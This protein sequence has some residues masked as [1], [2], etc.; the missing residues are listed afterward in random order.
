MINYISMGED[1]RVGIGFDKKRT[2]TRCCNNVVYGLIGLY[3]TV[4]CCRRPELA[5]DQIDYCR[6]LKASSSLEH[7]VT[8]DI[9]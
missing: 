3:N 7:A 5:I 8:G 9:I 1:A 2:N 6:S 4:C